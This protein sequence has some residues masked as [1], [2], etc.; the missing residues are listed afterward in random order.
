MATKPSIP[1]EGKTPP[2]SSALPKEAE[3][4]GSNTRELL[5]W[6]RS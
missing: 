6:F 3:D 1:G 5:A 4:V 2:P